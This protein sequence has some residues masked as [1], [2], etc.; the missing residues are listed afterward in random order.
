MDSNT[1]LSIIL[2][3]CLIL[4]VIVYVVGVE[5]GKA[6]CSLRIQRLSPAN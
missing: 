5:V 6:T 3:L 2:I 4:I 1:I